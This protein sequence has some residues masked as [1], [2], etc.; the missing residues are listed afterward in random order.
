MKTSSRSNRNLQTES[1]QR[2]SRDALIVLA[3]NTFIQLVISDLSFLNLVHFCPALVAA[4]IFILSKG[5]YLTSTVT[6]PSYLV[7]LLA[8]IALTS[9]ASDLLRDAVGSIPLINLRQLPACLVGFR[10]SISSGTPRTKFAHLNF[11]SIGIVIIGM[12]RSTLTTTDWIASGLSFGFMVWTLWEWIESD[13][14]NATDHVR[15]NEM[16]TS[17]L[18]QWKML[19]CNSLEFP[20]GIVKRDSSNK[21]GFSSVFMNELVQMEFA[22]AL[23]SD[24]CLVAVIEKLQYSLSAFNNLDGFGHFQPLL[25][26]ILEE[27]EGI[28][29]NGESRLYQDCELIQMH[30][31]GVHGSTSKKVNSLGPRFY[32]VFV[33]RCVLEDDAPY[34]YFLFTNTSDRINLE[35]MRR[36]AKLAD[37]KFSL[38]AQDMRFPLKGM[39]NMLGAALSMSSALEPNVLQLIRGAVD[40]TSLLQNT[41]KSMEDITRLQREEFQ[42]QCS[43][44]DLREFL[45]NS[46]SLIERQSR[47]RNIEV[48]NVIDSKVPDKMVTDRDRLKQILLNILICALKYTKQGK[49]KI[50]VKRWLNDQ[51]L[52]FSISFTGLLQEIDDET[53]ITRPWMFESNSLHGG[54][55]AYLET[56]SFGLVLDV[57]RRLAGI[58]GPEESIRVKTRFNVST[59]LSFIAYVIHPDAQDTCAGFT[60]M[61][62]KRIASMNLDLMR[63]PGLWA[64]RDSIAEFKESHESDGHNHNHKKI[65][66][67]NSMEPDGENKD[68]D[69]IPDECE[70][71]ERNSMNLIGKDYSKEISNNI[72]S[73]G[74]LPKAQLP[75]KGSSKERPGLNHKYPTFTSQFRRFLVKTQ[76]LICKI[77]LL[78]TSPSPRDGLLSRMPSSA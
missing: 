19:A 54:Q 36:R 40:Y 63:N 31:S 23:Q 1:I 20:V 6:V 34:L 33:T 24:D 12:Q 73:G 72:Q 11:L 58:L 64:Q 78:Y 4:V 16:T 22:E 2:Y 26:L 49:I 56:E 15:A 70:G 59:R 35:K 51:L 30:A 61:N 69:S 8:N 74:N 71:K 41:V 38:A 5:Q 13:N 53:G 17:Q 45:T 67:Q 29:E 37:R 62:L 10:L 48:I 55:E 52:N 39:S 76:G 42:L 77:C 21:K 3:A 65:D 25:S 75:L 43:I 60:L 18:T 44:F 7:T 32:D 68:D 14:R 9:S 66:R 27:S 46:I 28:L 50:R 47:I 57:S